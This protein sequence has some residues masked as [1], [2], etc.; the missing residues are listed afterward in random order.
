MVLLTAVLLGGALP[1]L[2]VHFLWVNLA[3]AILLGLT[4]VFE[5]KESDLMA[6]PPRDPQQPLFTWELLQRTALVSGIM[7][8]GAFWL[9][10]WELRSAGAS[11]AVARTAVVNVIVLVEIAYLFSCRSLHRSLFSI[12]WFSNPCALLGVAAMLGA[13]LLFTYAPFMN[14]LFRTAPITLESW[15]RI[16]GVAAVALAVVETEKW[17][18]IFRKRREK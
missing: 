7:V 13:Q 8:V 4:L 17:L 5:P 6:R 16:V 9:F 10:R 2:P 14:R 11:E 15:L 12:G 1:A 3:T 18:R